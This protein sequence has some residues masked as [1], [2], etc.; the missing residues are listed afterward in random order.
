V[1]GFSMQIQTIDYQIFVSICDEPCM[2][3]P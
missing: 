1:E 3:P 2:T